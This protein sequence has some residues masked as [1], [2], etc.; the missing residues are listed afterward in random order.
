MGKGTGAQ[1]PGTRRSLLSG[2]PFD[3][4]AL[5]CF[6]GEGRVWIWGSSLVILSL[7]WIPNAIL[8]LNGLERVSQTPRGAGPCG[9]QGNRKTH[10]S[11]HTPRQAVLAQ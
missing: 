5:L 9:F 4:I 6:R 11:A 3:A 10:H 7:Q 1:Q 8:V 2:T